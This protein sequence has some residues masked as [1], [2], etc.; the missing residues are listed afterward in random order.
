MIIAAT[1]PLLLEHGERVTTHDI[2][3]AAGIAEG[4]IFR[5]FAS[6]EALIEA[7]IDHAL[8]VGPFDRA[9]AGI[10]PGLPLE[11]AV[12]QVVGVLQQRVVDIWRLMSS[13][14]TRFHE[15]ARRPAVASEALVRLFEAHRRELTV[16][17]AEAALVVRSFTLAMTHPMMVSEAV[18]AAEVAR[19][20]LYGV[21]RGPAC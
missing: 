4:T 1:L 17:P 7:V 21:A 14:G 19:R 5:V 18:G 15:Q 6:K 20:F 16:E 10:D 13:V 2:A 9:I 3:D 8:D 12:A 11:E